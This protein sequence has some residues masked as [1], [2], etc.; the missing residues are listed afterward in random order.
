MPKACNI[1]QAALL[2]MIAEREASITR[3]TLDRLT[4]EGPGA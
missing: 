2:A 3:A 1:P 4:A